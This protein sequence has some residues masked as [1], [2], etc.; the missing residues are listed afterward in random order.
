MLDL[1]H[2]PSSKFEVDTY[3]DQ[4]SYVNT[5]STGECLPWRDSQFN[6]VCN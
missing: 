5:Q 2:P 6:F 1:T 3:L 4:A